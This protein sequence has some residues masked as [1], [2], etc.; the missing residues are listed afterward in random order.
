M[1]RMGMHNY[2]NFTNLVLS[3]L[4]SLSPV[5]NKNIVLFNKTAQIGNIFG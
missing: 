1:L 3:S 4:R 5:E 2:V